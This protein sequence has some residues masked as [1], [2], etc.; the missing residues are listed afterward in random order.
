MMVTVY[1]SMI[2]GLLFSLQFWCSSTSDSNIAVLVRSPVATSGEPTNIMVYRDDARRNVTFDKAKL[3]GGTRTCC[4]FLQY[5]NNNPRIP[6]DA[7]SNT[8]SEPATLTLPVT[9]PTDERHGIYSV[10]VQEDGGEE[11]ILRVLITNQDAT[12]TAAEYSM[13]ASQGEGVSLMAELDDSLSHQQLRWRKDGDFMALRDTEY[14]LAKAESSSVF[15]CFLSGRYFENLHAIMNLITRGCPKG[16]TGLNCME[17]C[18]RCFNGGVCSDKTASCL[19]PAGFSGN[20]CENVHGSNVFGQNAE[21]KCDNTA[22]DHDDGC[23]GAIIC[24]PEPFG[25]ICPAGYTGIDCMTACPEGKFGAN[26]KQ[27]CNCQNGVSCTKDTGVCADGMCAEGWKGIN[28]QVEDPCEVGVFGDLC[29]LPCSC[30]GEDCSVVESNCDRGCAV[31]WTGEACNENSGL[32]VITDLRH[33]KVNPGVE[34]SVTCFAVRNPA[35]KEEDLEL[36]G[37]AAMLSTSVSFGFGEKVY[38][39]VSTWMVTL[40]SDPVIMATCSIKGTNISQSLQLTPYEL[41]QYSSAQSAPLN[42]QPVTSTSISLTWPQ[43]EAGTDVGDGPVKEY[44][45]EYREEGGSFME[46]ERTATRLTSTITDLKAGTLY[47]FRIFL[48]REGTNGTGPPSAIQSQRT[49]CGVFTMSPTLML[50]SI[51]SR[52]ATF[53]VEI[54]DRIHWNCHSITVSLQRQESNGEWTVVQDLS[55]SLSQVVDVI[56]LVPCTRYTFRLQLDNPEDMDVSMPVE[57]MT[58]PE[59]LVVREVSV[60][61]VTIG[62]LDVSWLPPD[63]SQNNCALSSYTVMYRLLRHVACASDVTE[64]MYISSTTSSTS[65]TLSGL[66]DYAEYEVKVRA[67][68]EVEGMEIIEMG[69]TLPAAPSAAP[70]DIMLA[71]I[72]STCL[73]FTWKPPPCDQRNTVIMAYQYSLSLTN[74]TT[75]DTLVTDSSTK[76]EDIEL[77]GLIPYF[78]YDFTVRAVT[79]IGQGPDSEI[80]TSRTEEDVPPQLDPPRFLFTNASSLQLQW[81]S[82]YPPHGI[83][84]GYNISV[85]LIDDNQSN[86]SFIVSVDAEIAGEPPSFILTDLEPLRNY[87]I[88]VR[89]NTRIGPGN[90]SLGVILKTKEGLPSPPRNIKVSNKSKVSLTVE[91]DIPENPAGDIIRYEICNQALEKPYDPDFKVIPCGPHSM[92]VSPH[93]HVVHR[94]TSLEPSTVYGI[95]ISAYTS[96]GQGKISNITART[97]IADEFIAVQDDM[98]QISRKGVLATLSLPPLSDMYA[99]HYFIR[100]RDPQVLRRSVGGI[101]SYDDNPRD[102]ITAEIEKGDEG[103][104]FTI[105]DGQIYGMYRNVPLEEDKEYEIY[106]GTGSRVGED[107]EVVWSEPFPLML[108]TDVAWIYIVI[109]GVIFILIVLIV[110]VFL[111]KRFRKK[112]ADDID[113]AGTRNPAYVHDAVALEAPQGPKKRSKSIKVSD[114]ALYV[115]QKK[116]STTDNFLLEYE[117]LP[118]DQ[119]YSWDVASKPENHTKNRYRNIIPYDNSRVVLKMVEG[120]PHSDYFNA[121]YID[122]YSGPNKFIASHGPNRASVVDFWRLI[123]QEDCGKIVMLTPLKEEGKKKCEKYWPDDSVTHGNIVVTCADVKEYPTYTFRTLTVNLIGAKESRTVLHFHFT[124]WKDMKVPESPDPLMEFLQVVRQEPNPRIGPTVV[125]CSAGVGRTGTYIALD[126][127]LDMAAAEKKVNIYQWIYQ[128]RQRRVKMVQVP[129][130]YQFIFD[131]LVK[132]LVIGNTSLQV[133]SFRLHLSDLKKTNPRTKQSYLHD[134]FKNL[135]MISIRPHPSQ[136]QGA[137]KPENRNKNRFATVLPVDSCRPYLMTEAGGKSNMYINASFVNGFRRRDMF[138]ATQMPLENTILDFWRLV[139]DYNSNTIVMLN[140]MPHKS[141]EQ[142]WPDSSPVTFGPFTIQLLSR[143]EHDGIVISK[144]EICNTALQYQNFRTVLHLRCL[145]WPE[146][147]LVPPSPGTLLHLISK[148]NTWQLENE[149]SPILVHCIDG[150]GRTGVFCALISAIDQ[151]KAEQRVDI[152][153]IV[154]NMRNARSNMV[155]N[156]EQYQ[157]IFDTFLMQLENSSSYENVEI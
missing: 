53:M 110:G 22:G 7:M 32:G 55:T 127:M 88:M 17:D 81:Q 97:E 18:P 63:T 6:D 99:T 139:W 152:L 33:E 129:E 78:E 119:L 56:N 26:C 131:A 30:D 75:N 123:W 79:M 107:T 140:D 90:W 20:H 62:Q 14:S 47:E 104:P 21:Y 108:P 128:M 38:T 24:Y 149:D 91:W 52:I 141:L 50:D 72:S 101:G 25:C 98:L 124:D 9:M 29:T 133:D 48:V 5:R 73:R 19:C 36:L 89:A 95:E 150:I 11:T 31:P 96:A 106:V 69:T 145:G 121:S 3:E 120:D 102:Y 135:E 58:P 35:L 77:C 61:P 83:I 84:I 27:D 147:D 64:S 151:A 93:A 57:V 87:S 148:L 15:E 45:I 136:L 28:C 156:L 16:K 126:A 80:V 113:R 85:Q 122:G 112:K 109:A 54:P 155:Q 143:D 8:I 1:R 66:S 59:A 92:I 71:N 105:G 130:Q 34:T 117:T 153:H 42:F 115:K 49:L 134:Q 103:E 154:H 111:I 41:L 65:R 10:T 82:P 39:R 118:D 114:L 132:F 46:G 68:G 4:Q 51:T 44:V 23:Q 13:V 144:L 137:K 40:Q 100:V 12:I 94:I 146:Q 37:V 2:T 43:W 74:G 138:L 60:A 76:H 67:D 116:E 125:H 86:M 142:Y 157:C 70:A